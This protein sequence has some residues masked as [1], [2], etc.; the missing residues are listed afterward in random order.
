M[1]DTPEPR[2]EGREATSPNLRELDCAVAEEVMGWERI[3]LYERV[4]DPAFFGGKS[5]RMYREAGQS[6]YLCRPGRIAEDGG[7]EVMAREQVGTLVIGGDRDLPRYSSDLAAASQVEASIARRGLQEAYI[8][9]LEA[10]LG[11]HTSI[12]YRWLF[13]LVTAGPESRCRAAL[14]AVRGTT[15]D[16]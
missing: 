5:D 6:D 7:Q 13:A 11:D 2:L 4:L 12:R 1:P 3:T 14:A 8:Q 10:I 9:Q 15:P 16:G